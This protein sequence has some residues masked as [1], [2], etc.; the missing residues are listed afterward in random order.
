MALSDEPTDRN[1]T[2]GP[3]STPPASGSE[4]RDIPDSL[5]K[6]KILAAVAEGFTGDTYRAVDTTSG[7]TVLLRVV[8]ADLA[9]LPQF[10]RALYEQQTT[11]DLLIDH[12]NIAPLLDVGKIQGRHYFATEFVDGPSLADR[13]AQGP[14]PIEE[15]MQILTQIAEGLRAAHRRQL[16][17]GDLKP[18]DVFLADWQVTLDGAT[19]RLEGKVRDVEETMGKDL[20]HE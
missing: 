18:A 10:R 9:K 19:G 11:N 5:G 16:V 8:R 14:L 1:G 6:F 17:H 2:N 15:G 12:P 13:L 20:V 7:D 3:Q 4:G